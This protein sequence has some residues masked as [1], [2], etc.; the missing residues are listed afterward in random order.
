[1][2][3]VTQD[4]GLK[5]FYWM[6]TV[7][8]AYTKALGIGLGFDFARVEYDIEAEMVHVDGKPTLGWRFNKFVV[9]Q[10]DGIYQGVVAEFTGDD[11]QRQVQREMGDI[12]WLDLEDAVSFV[13]SAIPKLS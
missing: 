13:H 2:F 8:E 5:R 10:P 7:K 6:W 11:V 4:E 1:M 9:T 12:S 3:S